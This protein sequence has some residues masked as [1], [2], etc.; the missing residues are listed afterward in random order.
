MSI[1][2]NHKG[3][4]LINKILENQLNLNDEPKEKTLQ[5]KCLDYKFN[6]KNKV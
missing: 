3:K 5:Y 2:P 4:E 1:E 6:I